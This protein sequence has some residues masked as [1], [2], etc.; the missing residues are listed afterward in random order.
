[1]SIIS[2][3]GAEYISIGAMA[4]PA[5]IYFIVLGL[6]GGCAFSMSGGIRIQRIQKLLAAIRKKGDAPTRDELKTIIIYLITF[7]GFLS[8]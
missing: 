8:F 6:F 1:V 4:L 2:S 5:K 7:V 3:T